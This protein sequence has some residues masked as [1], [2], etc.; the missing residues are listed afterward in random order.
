MSFLN[1][2]KYTSVLDSKPSVIERQRARLIANLKD[3][4]I[5]LEDPL[6]AK[7][8]MKWIKENGQ[9]RLIEKRTSIRPWWRETIDGQVAFTVRAGLKKI[10]F[11]KGM[12]AILLPSKQ[13]LPSLINGLIKAVSDGELDHLLMPKEGQKVPQRKKAA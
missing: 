11:Q 6:H 10:E 8:C 5:R 3:Q 1:T 13:E 4:L 12:T 7:S 2:L 9:S